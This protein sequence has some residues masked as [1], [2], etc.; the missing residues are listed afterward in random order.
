MTLAYDHCHE[1]TIG[2]HKQKCRNEIADEKW[3]K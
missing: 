2:S 1:I 3:M